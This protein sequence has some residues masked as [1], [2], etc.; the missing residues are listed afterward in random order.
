MKY[1]ELYKKLTKNQL[2]VFSFRDLKRLFPK[3]SPRTLKFQVYFWKKKGWLRAIR[4]GFYEIAYPERKNIPDMFI[5]NRLYE[6]S[7]VSLETAL[8]TYS[9]IPEVAIGVTSVTTKATRRFGSFVYRTVRPKAFT[10]YRIIKEQGFDIKI[11][12]PEKALIDYLYLKLRTNGEISKRFEIKA[13]RLLDKK[14]L[15]IYMK[16]YPKKIKEEI[17]KIYANL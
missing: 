3:E 16:L 8:S 9:I 10:G 17:N 12:E 1:E 4:R 5:A 11:A 14:K 6:P 13:L 7:Y 2:Y 15:Q